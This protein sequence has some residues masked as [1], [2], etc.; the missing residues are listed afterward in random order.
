METGWRIATALSGI[1]CIIWAFFILD[2]VLTFQKE[3]KIQ[4]RYS[5]NDRSSF[6]KRFSFTIYP[7][8]SYIWGFDTFRMETYG[9]PPLNLISF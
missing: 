6:E 3:T 9:A 5:R 7:I 2:F 4:N 8:I 1:L